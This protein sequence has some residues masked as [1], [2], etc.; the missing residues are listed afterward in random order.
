MFRSLTLCNNTPVPTPNPEVQHLGSTL[1][2]ANC[3]SL[4]PGLGATFGNTF[5][6]ASRLMARLAAT[7]NG[8]SNRALQPRSPQATSRGEN[9]I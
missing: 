2:A 5:Y 1:H 6:P 8:H 9:L 7:E 3:A 4:P